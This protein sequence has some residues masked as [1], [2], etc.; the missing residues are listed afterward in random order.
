MIPDEGHVTLV[1]ASVGPAGLGDG[2]PLS[3]MLMMTTRT[4]RAAGP[5]LLGLGLGLGLIAAAPPPARAE[6]A[7][8][9]GD[10]VVFL[11]DSITAARGYGKVI[12]NYTLL[13]FPGRKVRFYNE[14]RGGDTA[15]GGLRRLDRDVFPHRPTVLVVAYRVNDIGWGTLADDAHKA[16]YL[17]GIG[18]IIDRCEAKGV[19]AVICSAAATAEDPET[20]ERGELQRLCDGGLALARRRGATAVDVQRP[21]REALRKV[22]EAAAATPAGQD[23]PRMHAAD[24]VHLNDLGQLAMAVAILKGLG[25]PAE[26]SSAAINAG[27][28]EAVDARGCRITGLTGDGRGLEF[29]RL[30]D[31]LPIN[32]GGFGALQYRFVPVPESL[33]RYTLAVTGLPEGRYDLRADGRALGTYPASQLASGLNL[34]SATANGW[35]PGGPWEAEAWALIRLTDARHE[36]ASALQ[37]ADQ[38]S[39]DHPGLA[40]LHRQADGASARLEDLQRALVRPRPFHFTLRPAAP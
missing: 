22:R 38:F 34:A 3:G 29:D 23:K 16:A 21:M 25:A 2:G 30:D 9:D 11:G 31:G 19:R 20:A 27:Q 37:A 39:A 33:N 24:G 1:L 36:L 10:T 15:A 7:L 5:V 13:R 8:R 28:P 12:E 4:M 32:F 35:E 6:F 40:D 18:G 17:D 26:V 14:G